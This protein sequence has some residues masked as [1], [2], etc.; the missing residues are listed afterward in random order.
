[1]EVI[2]FLLE[3]EDLEVDAVDS[4]GRSALH[5]AA[6]KRN[7]QVIIT[8]KRSGRFD[9]GARDVHGRTPLDVALEMKYPPIISEIQRWMRG[10]PS[11]EESEVSQVQV[12]E[13]DEEYDEIIGATTGL[14]LIQ[15][16]GQIFEEDEED[17]DGDGLDE[18][19]HRGSPSQIDSFLGVEMEVNDEEDD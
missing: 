10:E 12:I 11:G 15:G 3:N 18:E 2:G 19:Q 6:E 13:G 4:E 1:L 9:I 7:P 14:R 8:L 5:L 16:E 17:E